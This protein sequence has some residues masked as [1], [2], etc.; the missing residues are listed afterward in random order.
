M[1]ALS[2]DRTRF[3]AVIEKLW[4]LQYLTAQNFSNATAKRSARGL[5]VE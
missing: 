5:S 3:P 4:A 1:Q 2:V